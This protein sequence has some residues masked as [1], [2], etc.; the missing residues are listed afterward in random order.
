MSEEKQE[1]SWKRKWMDVSEV[2]DSYRPIPRLLLVA[3]GYL[4]WHVVNW[5]MMLPEPTTQQA[6]LV[7]TVTAIIPAIIGMYQN[8]G[9]IREN[10]KE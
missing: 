3:N 5:Y 9:K 1:I 4:V 10:S 2:I 8:A 7:T 6:A